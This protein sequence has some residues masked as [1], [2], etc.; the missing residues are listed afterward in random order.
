VIRT[1]LPRV[2]RKPRDGA[3]IV[4]ETA[5]V[6]TDESRPLVPGDEILRGHMVAPLPADAALDSAFLL[7]KLDNGEWCARTIG[8]DYNRVEFLGQLVANT[9]ALA[10]DEAEGWFL[11]ED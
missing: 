2:V 6:S 7:V 11:D 1:D 5:R 4:G 9:R 10:Q 3:A 8:D